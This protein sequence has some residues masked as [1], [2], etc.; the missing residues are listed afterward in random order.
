MSRKFD[1]WMSN[2]WGSYVCME[3]PCEGQSGEEHLCGPRRTLLSLPS[4]RSH[5]STQES[6]EHT[7]TAN[8]SR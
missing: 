5:V 2:G 1:R 8:T 6:G 4:H 3:E 7:I